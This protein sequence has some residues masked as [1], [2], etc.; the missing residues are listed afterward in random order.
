MYIMFLFI[1]LL[2]NYY[3]I[4]SHVCMYLSF[5]IYNQLINQSQHDRLKLGHQSCQELGYVYA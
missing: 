2:F 1:Y 3:L 4:A 5:I